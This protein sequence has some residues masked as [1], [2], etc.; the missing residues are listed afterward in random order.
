MK[1]PT[2]GNRKPSVTEAPK[3]IKNFVKYGD[4]ALSSFLNKKLRI[5]KV[6]AMGIV[7]KRPA[8]KIFLNLF[9]I[10]GNNLKAKKMFQYE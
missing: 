5:K 2:P 7:T 6:N 8:M 1:T 3:N 9:F 10:F 4:K